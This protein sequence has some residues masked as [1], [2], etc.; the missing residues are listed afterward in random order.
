[1]TEILILSNVSSEDEGRKI[2]LSLIEEKIA[3]CVNVIPKIASYYRWE[4][5]IQVDVE[6]TLLIKATSE[7]YSKIEKR[8]IELHSY[9]LPEIISFEIKNGY[10]P[11]IEWLNAQCK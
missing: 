3:A 2:A 1:M 5:K 7:M 9:E 10:K 8:I 6:C 11:Y 4:D